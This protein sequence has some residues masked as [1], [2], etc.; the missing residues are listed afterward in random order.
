MK[1]IRDCKAELGSSPSLSQVADVL[2]HILDRLEAQEKNGVRPKHEFPE[3]CP[4][5][6][7]GDEDLQ[8]FLRDGI[9]AVISRHAWPFHVWQKK[10]YMPG[11]DWHEASSEEVATIVAHVLVELRKAFDHHVEKM[12]WLDDDPN[13]RL[14]Q[15][16]VLVYGLSPSKI[17]TALMKAC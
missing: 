6:D 9:D 14:P 16:S 15:A 3:I 10:I 5:P 17:K 2:R 11:D 12:G 13:G 7:I 8:L 1:S 4:F